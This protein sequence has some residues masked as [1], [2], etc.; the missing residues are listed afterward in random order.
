MFHKIFSSNSKNHPS[1]ASEVYPLT[2]YP[3]RCFST[4]SDRLSHTYG[5]RLPLLALCSMLLF[6]LFCLLLLSLTESRRHQEALAHAIAPQILRIHVIANSDSPEDQTVKRKVKEALLSQIKEDLLQNEAGTEARVSDASFSAQKLRL[7]AYFQFH[8]ADLTQSAERILRAHGFSYPV[9]IELGPHYFSTRAYDDTA[10]PCGVYDSVRILLG[11]ARGHNWWGILYPPLAM[12]GSIV[13]EPE[14]NAKH[15]STG[16]VSGTLM[17]DHDMNWMSQ[18]KHIFFD[19]S[20][21]KTAP[22]PVSSDTSVTLRV[23]C[24]FLSFLPGGSE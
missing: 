3:C 20:R 17:F 23:T 12:P 6:L 22:A 21:T 7:R 15:Q 16:S 4:G 24:R 9:S 5:G 10:F 13:P 19:M 18:K 1:S 11:D 14:E 2:R 8:R